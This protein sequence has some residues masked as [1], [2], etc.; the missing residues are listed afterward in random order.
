MSDERF[1][2]H[3]FPRPKAGEQLLEKGLQILAF[4][5]E[6][7]LVLAPEIVK[8][9]AS[10]LSTNEEEVQILQRRA[11]FTEIARSEVPEHSRTF[12]PISMAFDIADLRASGALPVIYAPQGMPD[13]MVSLLSTFIVRGHGIRRRS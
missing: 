7:G 8:W 6:V 3:S 10:A 11:C 1:F 13:N 5:K 4:M 12:G 9:N 2:Y